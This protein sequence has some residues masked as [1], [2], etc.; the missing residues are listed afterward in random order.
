LATGALDPI[1][2]RA[3]NTG[4]AAAVGV[5]I[6]FFALARFT[7]KGKGAPAARLASLL[8][9]LIT[10]WLF[11]AVKNPPAAGD[12]ATAAAS[13]TSTA[14]SGLGHFIADVFSG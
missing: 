7:L 8:A 6:A 1:P 9:V 5:V 13:G 11:V 3:D 2:G 14:I 12:V 4:V 10:L